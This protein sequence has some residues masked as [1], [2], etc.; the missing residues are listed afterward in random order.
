MVNLSFY[1]KSALLALDSLSSEKMLPSKSAAVRSAEAGR[2]LDELLGQ[3]SLNSFTEK[4]V[5]DMIGRLAD[6]VTRL[7]RKTIQ[8]AEELI[9]KDLEEKGVLDTVPD[10]VSYD[11]RNW[12][13]GVM[14]EAYRAQFEAYT[15]ICI[16][17]RK[18]ALQKGRLDEET[19]LILWLLR[20]A[21]AL[22]DIFGADEQLIVKHN[23]ESYAVENP[24]MKEVWDT[25]FRKESEFADS[26][27]MAQDSSVIFPFMER[28]T[29]VFIHSIVVGYDPSERREHLTEILRSHGHEVETVN[30]QGQMLTR[31]DN[32]FYRIFPHAKKYGRTP[33]EGIRILPVY[34]KFDE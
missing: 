32:Q 5:R 23:A 11:S 34:F 21:G 24:V 31:I 33:L 27:I 15:E 28:R 30:W 29:S 14:K 19:F 4:E 13:A 1:E 25:G 8:G 3:K 26:M 20:E 12:S 9:R 17:V 16:D 10:L 7:F 22:Y 18:K 2:M 6:K